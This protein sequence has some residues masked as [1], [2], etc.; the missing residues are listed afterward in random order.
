MMMVIM[1]VFSL[2]PFMVFKYWNKIDKDS[3]LNKFDKQLK[4][5]SYKNQPDHF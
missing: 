5:N 3:W 4:M 2:I 1:L